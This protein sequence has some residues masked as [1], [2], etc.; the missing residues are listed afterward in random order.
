MAATEVTK[1][2]DL[3]AVVNVLVGDD[4]DETVD[5]EVDADVRRPV[6]SQIV[7]VQRLDVRGELVLGRVHPLHETVAAPWNVELCQ[8]SRHP[9]KVQAR[10]TRSK[11]PGEQPAMRST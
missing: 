9:S 1:Q 5:G 8:S 10:Y 2:P 4:L 6:S 11:R 3:C 7:S